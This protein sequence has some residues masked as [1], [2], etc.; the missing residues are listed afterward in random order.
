M[1]PPQLSLVLPGGHFSCHFTCHFTPPPPRP[2]PPSLPL[3]PAVKCLFAAFDKLRTPEEI[4]DTPGKL[5][6]AVAP[7]RYG[8]PALAK[9]GGA[10]AKRAMRRQ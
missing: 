9:A 6:V 2:L 10:P 3:F 1:R 8:T 4:L 7:G 5:M